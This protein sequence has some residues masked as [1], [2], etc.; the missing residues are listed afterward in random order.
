MHKHQTA[1]RAD[2]LPVVGGGPAGLTVANRLSEDPTVNVLVIEAGPADAGEP[3]VEIPGLIGDDIGGLYDWN[4]STVPQVY[5][6]GQPRSLPQ[7][8]AMGGGT[9]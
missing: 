8:R 9:I 2:C 4:L 7:G 5:L 6:D 1:A 3:E